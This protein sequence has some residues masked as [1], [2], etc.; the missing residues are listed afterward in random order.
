MLVAEGQDIGVS[1]KHNGKVAKELAHMYVAIALVYYMVFVAYLLYLWYRKE[2]FQALANTNRSRTWSTSA[3]RCRECL[4]QVDVHN[5][6]AHIS[7]A[8]YTKHRVEVGSII[9]HKTT[10]FVYKSLYLRN[11]TL[12]KTKCIRIGHHHGCNS[13]VKQSTQ[14][15]YIDNTFCCRFYLNYFQ[16]AYSCRCRVSAM[17]RVGYN[18]LSTFHVATTLVIGAYNHKSGKLSVCTCKWVECEF[19]Q[20]RYSRKSLLHVV[21]YLQSSL[22]SFF[23]L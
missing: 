11:L 17:C 10:T 16:S 23:W 9:I 18:N 13:I 6:E 2:L 3:M 7:R 15:V 14:I 1:S 21:V 4:M 19:L 8:A 12:K 20:A 5:V 22:A